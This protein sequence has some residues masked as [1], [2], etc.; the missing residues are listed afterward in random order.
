MN[1]VTKV[2]ELIKDDIL[3]EGYTIESITYE[4]EDGIYYLR[5]VI[6]KV[7]GITVDDCVIVSKIVN[8]I[9]DN[10]QNINLITDNYILDVCSK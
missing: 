10:P 5:I 1:I 2:S 8:P 9:L 7:G 4:K 6:D 3:K